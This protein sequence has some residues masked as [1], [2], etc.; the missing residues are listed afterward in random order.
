MSEK[1]KT[2][3]LV[4]IALST[5]ISVMNGTMFN[6]V[7]PNIREDFHLTASMMGWVSTSFLVIYAVSTAIYGKATERYSLKTLVIFA[8]SILVVSDLLGFFAV[9]YTMVL[10]ARALQAVG[11]AVVPSLS[12]IIPARYVSLKDRGMAFGLMATGAA[13][14]ST[15]GPTIA[16]FVAETFGWESLFLLSLGLP[17]A[18]PLYLKLLPEDKGHDV[19]IDF[20]GGVL[21]ASGSAFLL[22][23]ITHFSLLFFAIS[24]VSWGLFA[25]R[26]LRAKHPFIQLSLFRNQRYVRIL[27]FL[28]VFTFVSSTVSFVTPLYLSAVYLA[29]PSEIGLLILPA[30]IITALLGA[31]GGKIVDRFGASVLYRIAATLL[32]F[33]FLITSVILGFP[34]S[35]AV[36][37]LVFGVLGTSYLTMALSNFTSYTLPEKDIGIGMGLYSLVYFM[38]FAFSS[39]VASK[40][41]DW[42]FVAFTVNLSTQNEQAVLYSNILIA[43]AFILLL[44][45]V[46]FGTQL[47]HFRPSSAEA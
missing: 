8:F 36:V 32:L 38:A 34:K 43:F 24:M 20:L 25:W 13:L 22:I 39:V 41:I 42:G 6:I 30:T 5:I 27:G 7:L 19:S 37:L 14:G 46:V 44:S 28:F 2:F 26:L 33:Y 9:N 16:G 10:A 35:W 29:G 12:M 11:T 17:L 23:T 4:L 18:L 3:L 1:R 45:I 40:M 15:I 21:L 31:V 47:K